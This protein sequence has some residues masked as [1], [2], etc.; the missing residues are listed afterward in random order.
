[1]TWG[2]MDIRT[3][4]KIN[5]DLCGTPI[6]IGHGFSQVELKTTQKMVADDKGL[7]HGGFVFGLAD[8]A[9]MVAVNNPNVVL[10]SSSVKFKKPVKVGEVIVAKAKV[11][12]VDG[13]KQ[14]VEAKVFLLEDIVFEGEFNCYV[15]DQHVLS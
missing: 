1:M 3:H 5:K 2:E 10:A 6:K 14:T 4:K 12:K 15:L 7:V 8:Y 9:A 13:R 11:L